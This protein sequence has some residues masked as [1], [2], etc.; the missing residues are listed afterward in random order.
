MLAD[1]REHIRKLAL[2]RILKIRERTTGF[3]PLRV[4]KLPL[5][6]FN[7]QDYIDLIDWEKPTEPPLTKIIPTEIISEALADDSKVNSLI[8]SVFR[9]IPCHTQSTE[10]CIKLV[11]ESCTAVCG[12]IRREGWIRNKLES[13]RI[14]PSFNT[15]KDFKTC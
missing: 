13:C 6:N 8:L 9:G 14:M 2:R 15:K 10:R 3:T 11:T 4:F 5:F 7:A 1:D 12:P